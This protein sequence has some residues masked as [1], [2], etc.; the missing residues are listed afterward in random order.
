MQVDFKRPYFIQGHRYLKGENKVLDRFSERLPRDAEVLEGPVQAE[1]VEDTE[2]GG[3]PEDPAAVRRQ[4]QK[5]VGQI[6]IN[7]PVN[8]TARGDVKTDLLEQLLGWEPTR[9]EVN[10]A[11]TGGP[12]V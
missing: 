5:A 11:L 9:S 4:I 6:D 12:A 2:Q 10:E 1:P 7:D 3:K 8:L